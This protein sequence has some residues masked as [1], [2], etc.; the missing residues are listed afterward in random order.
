MAYTSN[1]AFYAIFLIVLIS[2]SIFI[3]YKYYYVSTSS[4]YITLINNPTQLKGDYESKIN[5]LEIINDRTTLMKDG[6]GYG[7]TILIDMYISNNA[8][9]MNWGSSFSSMK[10]ILN[11]NDNL[12]LM[13]NPSKGRLY[14]TVKYLNSMGEIV[15]TEIDLGIVPMQKWA[16]HAIII[17]E[18]HIIYVRDSKLIKSK[19]INF[20]PI[21]KGMN[22]TIGKRNKN[23]YGKIRSLQLVTKPLNLNEV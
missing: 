18:N 12:I 20:I 16:K 19:T 6:N 21:I 2:I 22:L 13:Y 15:M 5:L 23:F 4:D 10:Q 1:L 7:I 8:G 14:L 17:D 11:L 9:N 3:Y